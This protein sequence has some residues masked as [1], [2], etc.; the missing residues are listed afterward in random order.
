MKGIGMHA[1]VRVSLIATVATAATLGISR[2]A[3]AQAPFTTADIPCLPAPAASTPDAW[4]GS[5]HWTR[6]NTAGVC[7]GWYCARMKEPDT[8][9]EI[10]FCGDWATYKKSAGYISTIRSAK[11][12]LKSL[13]TLDKRILVEDLELFKFTVMPKEKP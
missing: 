11:D 5:S 9:R 12:P 10:T 4:V 6:M 8:I 13:Q 3:Y 1:I 2:C 7:G